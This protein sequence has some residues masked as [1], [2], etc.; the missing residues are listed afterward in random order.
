MSKKYDNCRIASF[1]ELQNA[2]K[3]G[4]Y[5]SLVWNDEGSMQNEKWTFNNSHAD[6]EPLLVD[7]NSM[8]LLISIY[9]KIES[10]DVK[11]KVKFAIGHSRWEFMKLA[12]FAWQ[13]ARFS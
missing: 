6:Y 2:V 5:F 10:K 7:L 13:N 8:K 1:E 9:D 3:T 4:Q 12:K 11:E